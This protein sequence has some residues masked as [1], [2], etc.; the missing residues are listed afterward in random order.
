MKEKVR[1]S[2]LDII[3]VVAAFMVVMVHVGDQFPNV[4]QIT[5]VGTNGV[6]CFFVLSGYLILQS[7]EKCKSYKEFYIKRLTKIAPG[8]YATLLII[9]IVDAVRYLFVEG[10]SYN[11]LFFN[12]GPN[13]IHFLGG[14]FSLFAD[15]Y[16]I[17]PF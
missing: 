14:A 7:L 11:Q 9:Y 10:M 2:N 15:V 1:N 8:Y 3:R 6:E 16:S 5:G 12:D 4:R 13:S 17:Q